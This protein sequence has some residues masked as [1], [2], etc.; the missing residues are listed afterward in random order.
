VCVHL[1]PPHQVGTRHDTASRVPLVNLR[2]CSLGEQN[3]CV[4]SHLVRV[5]LG[6]TICHHQNVFLRCFVRVRSRNTL[7][8]PS[9]ACAISGLYLLARKSQHASSHYATDSIRQSMCDIC[10]CINAAVGKSSPFFSTI[11]I[12]DRRV[13][14]LPFV[15]QSPFR[16]FRQ[17]QP[18]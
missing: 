8:A 9:K 11:T 10:L 7:L 3:K 15:G 5:R 4:I 2:W 12:L 18:G 17:N 13:P 16:P 14:L 1:Q 6:R